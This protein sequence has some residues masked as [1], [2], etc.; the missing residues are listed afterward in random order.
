[1]S[2]SN[3]LELPR[4]QNP[5]PVAL[6]YISISGIGRPGVVC[7]GRTIPGVV[8]FPPPTAT[9]RLIKGSGGGSGVHGPTGIAPAPVGSGGRVCAL[10]IASSMDAD[11]IAA[12]PWDRAHI[13]AKAWASAVRP[14]QPCWAN[15]PEICPI[16]MSIPRLLL[17]ASLNEVAAPAEPPSAPP[18]AK[19]SACVRPCAT[20]AGRPRP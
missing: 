14:F 5:P 7:P 4:H 19:A 16:R 2:S 20:G 6:S 10:L 18:I 15:C 17:L 8:V 9:G 3:S 12:Q 13:I 11:N 1:M